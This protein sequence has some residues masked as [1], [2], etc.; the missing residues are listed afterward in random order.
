RGWRVTPVCE[1]DVSGR[2]GHWRVTQLHP[3]RRAAS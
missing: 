1:K 3:A 2:L